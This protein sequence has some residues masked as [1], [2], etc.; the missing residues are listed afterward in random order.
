MPDEMEPSKP[1]NLSDEEEGVASQEPTLEA[2]IPP[3]PTIRKE[4]VNEEHA[5]G[6][7]AATM[8]LLAM[9]PGLQDQEMEAAVPQSSEAEEMVEI[10]RLMG[11]I[12]RTIEQA[13]KF[14]E[15]GDSFSMSLRAGQLKVADHYPFLDPFGS[16]FEYMDGQIVFVGKAAPVEFVNGLTEAMKLAVSSLVHSSLQGGRL[17]AFVTEDL[18]ALLERNLAELQRYNLDRAIEEILSF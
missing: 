9:P 6:L 13:V 4:V 18:N 12:A 7:S 10:K 16:E 17:R 14:V 11:E 3:Q 2:D 15:P 1:S 8:R 5:G